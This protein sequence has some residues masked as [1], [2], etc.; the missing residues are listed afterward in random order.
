LEDLEAGSIPKGIRRIEGIRALVKSFTHVTDGEFDQAVR[1]HYAK[2][3]H[4][5]DA[6]KLKA[7]LFTTCYREFLRRGRRRVNTPRVELRLVEDQLPHVTPDQIQRMDAGLLMEAL[8]QLDEHHRLPVTLFYLRGLTYREIAA[9]LEIPVGT[10]MSRLARGKDQ[11]RNL[12][13][14]PVRSEASVVGEAAP[15]RP[16]RRER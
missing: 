2:G 10:V 6:S 15:L 1:V 8:Q 5:E 3:R 9:L 4:V 13:G 14:A 7:W 11:L 16:E 12:L